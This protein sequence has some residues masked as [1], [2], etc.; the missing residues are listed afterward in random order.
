MD[1][2]TDA[3]TRLLSGQIFICFDLIGRKRHLTSI[4]LKNLHKDLKTFDDVTKLVMHPT[5][6]SCNEL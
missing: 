5:N 1:F 3:L 6:F 4:N 2:Q